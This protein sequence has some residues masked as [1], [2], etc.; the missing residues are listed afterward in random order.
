MKFFE[1]NDNYL[2]EADLPILRHLEKIEITNQKD[3]VQKQERTIFTCH[4]SENQYFTNKS[5]TATLLYDDESIIKSKGTKIDWI[6]NPTISKVEKKQRNKRTNQTRVKIEEV[7]N[8][9]FF[10]SFN[11]FSIDDE[12]DN[13]HH[14]E[15]HE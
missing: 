7:Q 2:G 3:P 6:N 5:L 1:N 11:D 14:N 8:T 10:E 13:K 9:S 15:E 12:E 4:F